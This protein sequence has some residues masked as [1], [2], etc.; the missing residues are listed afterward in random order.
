MKSQ[1]IFIFHFFIK[2]RLNKFS[3]G[4]GPFCIF[5]GELFICPAHFSAGDFSLFSLIFKTF[6][7][8]LD[9]NNFDI[10]YKYCLSVFLLCFKFQTCV[11]L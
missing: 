11:L 2:A 1:N 9:L 10:C 5:Y 4:E 8:I 7:L 3:Y 6:P